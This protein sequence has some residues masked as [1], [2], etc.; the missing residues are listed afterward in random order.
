MYD[1]FKFVTRD[2][3]DAIGLSHMIGTDLLRAY[4]HGFFMDQRLYSRLKLVSDPFTYDTYRKERVEEK[5]K[6][7]VQERITF[8]KRLPKVNKDM[9]E[10]LLSTAKGKKA[11]GDDEEGK[12]F[13]NPIGDNRFADLFKSKD[14]EIDETSAE[15]QLRY[16]QGLPKKR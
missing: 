1:D 13:S 9:A 12:I 6:A 5:V 14:F 4:M 15:F 2:E 11:V 8:N 7:K 3:L 10:R 16:P